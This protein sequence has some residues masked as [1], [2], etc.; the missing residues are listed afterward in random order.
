MPENKKIR[1]IEKKEL[2]AKK[3]YA[4]YNKLAPTVVRLTKEITGVT[5]PDINKITLR[6]VS[7]EKLLQQI[8]KNQEIGLELQLTPTPRLKK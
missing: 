5:I 8:N 3:N 6:V 2:N 1:T 7:K 4:L